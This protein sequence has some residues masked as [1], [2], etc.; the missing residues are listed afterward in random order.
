M[1]ILEVPDSGLILDEFTKIKE[2]FDNYNL[3]FDK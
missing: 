1:T 3:F 2:F